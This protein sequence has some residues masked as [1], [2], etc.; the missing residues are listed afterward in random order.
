MCDKVIEGG[1]DR[2]HHNEDIK[3]INESHCKNGDKC[4]D[5]EN[6]ACKQYH[7]KKER[8]SMF[9]KMKNNKPQKKKN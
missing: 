7:T 6:K 4:K 1:C 8:D 3:Y 5:F 9:E 2:Y